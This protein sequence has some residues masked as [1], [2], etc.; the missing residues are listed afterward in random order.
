M[1][2]QPWQGTCHEEE[3][4]S[5]GTEIDQPLGHHSMTETDQYKK[6]SNKHKFMFSSSPDEKMEFSSPFFLNGNGVVSKTEK[7]RGD[8]YESKSGNEIQMARLKNER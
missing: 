7:G 1:E 3:L 8:S 6:T 5:K 2:R 4:Q